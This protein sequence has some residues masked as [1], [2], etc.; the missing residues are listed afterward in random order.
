[1]SRYRVLWEQ[2]KYRLS[3]GRSL[4]TTKHLDVDIYIAGRLNLRQDSDAVRILS[5]NPAGT[6]GVHSLIHVEVEHASEPAVVRKQHGGQ[7]ASP[8]T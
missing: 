3:D 1:M 6:M 2:S 4:G 5:W 8:L 7:T